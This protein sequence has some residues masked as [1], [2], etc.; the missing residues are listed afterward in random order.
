MWYGNPSGRHAAKTAQQ[1]LDVSIQAIPIQADNEQMCQASSTSATMLS[2][3]VPATEAE[4]R[5]HI[6]PSVQRTTESMDAFIRR[7]CVW[8]ARMR[9]YQQQFDYSEQDDRMMWEFLIRS[10]GLWL[11]ALQYSFLAS[12]VSVQKYDDDNGSRSEGM[13]QEYQSSI[14]SCN[15][16]L[17]WSHPADHKSVMTTIRGCAT[18]DFRNGTT[19]CRQGCNH[20]HCCFV[21]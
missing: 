8:C 21:F 4:V 17:P 1:R 9:Q 20:C 12:N 18:I 19:R 13:K 2:L 14:R 3:D 15:I 16:N 10:P 6:S 7:T 11:H 5:S